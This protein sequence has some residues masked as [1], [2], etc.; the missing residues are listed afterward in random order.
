MFWQGIVS[1]GTEPIDQKHLNQEA[2]KIREKG[3]KISRQDA[4]KVLTKMVSAAVSSKASN[5]FISIPKLS[6]SGEGDDWI[7][8]QLAYLCENNVYTY[9]AKLN[10]KDKTTRNLKKVSITIDSALSITKLNRSIKV[11]QAIGRGSNSAKDLLS[12]KV[13]ILPIRSLILLS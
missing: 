2:R 4:V 10:K 3:K 7:I 1:G 6:I 12:V 11:G 5:A 8:Q 9:D 13:F